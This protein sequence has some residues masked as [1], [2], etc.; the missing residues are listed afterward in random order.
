MCEGL[1]VT[2]V[3]AQI[4]SFQFCISERHA[5]TKQKHFAKSGRCCANEH[6]HTW[7]CK[8]GVYCWVSWCLCALW[9]FSTLRG[10]PWCTVVADGVV[11]GLALSRWAKPP[12]RMEEQS[13]VIADIL[14]NGDI[15]LSGGKVGTW[16]G[17]SQCM[18]LLRLLQIQHCL[19]LRVL[20]CE[21]W[22]CPWSDFSRANICWTIC[23]S[24]DA[25]T[26]LLRT[27]KSSARPQCSQ[28]FCFSFLLE[29]AAS[30]NL[31]YMS[32][33]GVRR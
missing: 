28:L 19:W 18:C 33:T 25:C 11:L 8:I 32:I 21:A 9:A 17:K 15:S 3:T 20:P 29:P 13:P 4:W 5:Q 26:D 14:L 16:E 23:E 2:P 24:L 27:P 7:S 30:A 10:Q 31:N 6:W 12:L 1:P 22:N